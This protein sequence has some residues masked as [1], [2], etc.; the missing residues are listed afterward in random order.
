[1]SVLNLR[2]QKLKPGLL[3]VACAVLCLSALPAGSFAAADA[4]TR[5]DIEAILKK[6]GNS[7]CEFQRNGTWYGG[8]EA[9]AHL[10]RKFEYLDRRN[11]ATSVN[12]FIER[13]GTTSSLSG[14]PYSV[15]CPGQPVI[16]GSAWLND[17]WRSVKQ[18]AGQP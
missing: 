9:A 10:R 17:A 6:L 18:N 1:M 11:L 14:K 13:A 3:S 4:E 15:R 7:S 2:S 5:A 16:S 8:E 12:I